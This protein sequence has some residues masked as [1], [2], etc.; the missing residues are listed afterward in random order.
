MRILHLGGN[1]LGD[2]VLAILRE[3]H[4]G[5]TSVTTLEELER[6][7]RDGVDWMVSAGFR[8]TIPGKLLARATHTCNVHT[9]SLPWGRGAHPNV[10]M[11]VNHEPPGVSV[12]EMV[13]GVDAGPVFAQKPIEISFADNARDVYLRLEDAAVSLFSEVW[14][15]MVSGQ[16]EPREQSGD[17]SEHRTA[18]FSDL[19]SIDM[20]HEVTW[21][22]A[23]D[24]LRAATFPPHRNLVVTV[25]GRRYHVE[26]QVTEIP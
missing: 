6:A 19:V 18:E 13:E 22:R 26:I 17:G 24:T 11:I 16:I 14:P 5:V 15:E 7:A 9:S 2:H 20:D 3:H 25:D 1:R 10:W 12:H 21:R 23:L 4:G 8:Q